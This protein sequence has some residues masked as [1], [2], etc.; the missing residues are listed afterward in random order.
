[1]ISRQRDAQ[2][3]QFCLHMRQINQCHIWRWAH[4]KHQEL[5]VF[6]AL[7]RNGINNDSSLKTMCH[8]LLITRN[9][10]YLFAQLLWLNCLF[11]AGVFSLPLSCF[12]PVQYLFSCYTLHLPFHDAMLSDHSTCHGSPPTSLFFLT[13]TFINA[14][15]VNPNWKVPSGRLLISSSDDMEEKIPLELFRNRPGC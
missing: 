1:M 5:I 2:S 9:Q 12:C 6:C 11:P 13:P 3:L 14:L 7:F 4:I 8:L 10:L 15:T